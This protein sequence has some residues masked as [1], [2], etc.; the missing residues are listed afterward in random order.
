[1]DFEEAT[2]LL[3]QPLDKKY[4]KSRDGRGGKPVRYADISYLE[5]R[6]AEVDAGW[7]V[8]FRMESPTTLICAIKILG[9]QRSGTAGLYVG[10][11]YLKYDKKLKEEVPVAMTPAVAHTIT[12]L[13]E[14]QAFRRACR[15]FRLGAELWEDE[16]D[17]RD[18]EDE[19]THARSPRRETTR[20]DGN[21]KGPSENQKNWLAGLGVPENVIV[22]LDTTRR[23]QEDG[24]W[25]STLG[26][27]GT[28][29]QTAQREDEDYY[30][31]NTLKF[32][33]AALKRY[34]PSIT[35]AAPPARTKGKLA[36]STKLVLEDEDDTDRDDDE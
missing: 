13:A 20:R 31:A 32:V 29:L 26:L 22:Q 14:A 2:K 21:K 33:K 3:E 12:T 18:D 5:T 1:M 23:E 10:D 6:L 35:L 27:V 34:A 28:S 7:Q 36:A 11:T 17:S 9:V 19:D 25:N 30:E 16:D 15:R 8:D 4:I 24:N